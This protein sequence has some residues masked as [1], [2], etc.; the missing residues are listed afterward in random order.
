MK[1]ST[2]ETARQKIGT[3]INAFSQVL[4][5]LAHSTVTKISDFYRTYD[6]A[7]AYDN[8]R[9]RENFRLVNQ[10]TSFA[11][12]IMSAEYDSVSKTEG[13]N[14]IKS[15]AKEFIAEPDRI[16]RYGNAIQSA[17]CMGIVFG[18]ELD[19]LIKKIHAEDK[20]NTQD[21]LHFDL[22]KIYQL[23]GEAGLLN[24]IGTIIGYHDGKKTS[25]DYNLKIILDWLDGKVNLSK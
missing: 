19:S 17:F 3:G 11:V 16:D 6:T 21:P 4:N 8:Y 15:K 10:I 18:D 20:I 13:L 22:D 24:A 23:L 14:K 12:S 5:G 1:P 9:A 25:P 7:I 2:V